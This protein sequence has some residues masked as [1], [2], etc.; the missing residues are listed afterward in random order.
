MAAVVAT[1][2][3]TIQKN[4]QILVNVEE[5]LEDLIVVSYSSDDKKFQGVL[6]DSKKRF[7]WIYLRTD[8]GYRFI[9]TEHIYSYLI[10]Y[11]TVIYLLVYIIFIQL[12]QSER[13]M[14]RAKT[15]NYI[16]LVKDLLTKNLSLPLEMAKSPKKPIQKANLS[17][18]KR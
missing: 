7:V 8:S 3:M 5:A 6:L 9:S 14:L 4:S 10:Y 17:L 16:P 15:T 11:F 18:D 2:D 12:S 13:K 1:A